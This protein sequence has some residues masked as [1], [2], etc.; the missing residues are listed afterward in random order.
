MIDAAAVVG[1]ANED[2]RAIS[3]GGKN[4]RRHAR[5]TTLFTLGR[6]FDAVI[7][8]I[9]K[10]MKNRL[11]HLVQHRPV[12]LDLAPFDLE[13]DFLAEC[14]RRIAHDAWKALEHS[15]HRHHSARHNLVLEIGEDLRRAQDGVRELLVAK[16]FSDLRDAVAR[17][18]QFADDI[19]Q[20]VETLGLDAN[21]TRRALRRRR[22]SCRRHVAVFF[23]NRKL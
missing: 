19:H 12:Q 7:K 5:L 9:A 3:L 22:R 15:P 20:R 14:L 23:R 4:Q 6:A 10:K 2:R 13:L 18:D 8:G 1:D 11:T 21:V 17:N 16:P